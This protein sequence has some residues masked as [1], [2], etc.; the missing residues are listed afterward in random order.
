VKGT[1]AAGSIGPDLSHVG[2]RGTIASGI[3]DNDRESLIR[4]ISNPD[5]EKPGVV[6]MPAFE[7]QMTQEQIASIADYL[8]SLQ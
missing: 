4:W 6:L 8:L 1:T 7:S 2:G 3:M 5:R